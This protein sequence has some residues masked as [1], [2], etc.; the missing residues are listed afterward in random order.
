[1]R[2]VDISDFIGALPSPASG[3]GSARR[4]DAFSSDDASG[5]TSQATNIVEAIE[6]GATGL[7]LDEDT[8]ATNFMIR[9]ARMQALVAP[10]SEPI[11]PFLDRVRALH[12]ARG[13]STVLVMG[14]SGDYFDV[15][16][17]VV[18]MRDFSAH[19]ATEAA[20]AIARARPTG[21]SAEAAG[22][23]GPVR[24]RM[25]VAESFALGG[26]RGRRDRVSA[27]SRELIL[28][29]RTP[30]DLRHL[31]QIA[32]PSQTRAIALALRTAAA[33]IMGDDA[34]CAAGSAPSLAETLDS[35]ERMLDAEGLD[36]L[37]D[38]DRFGERGQHPGA[39]ARPRRF[40]IASAINRYRGLQVR[41]R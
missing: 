36:A 32:D 5:S 25:P 41:Q 23:L 27:K 33:R 13:V 16:D 40:E 15:A 38:V 11:T 17:R 8:S 9:D 18:L 31:S 2:G 28:F 4:T 12:D 29:G 34:A 1:V 30:I 26:G 20:R 21:R 10:E 6:V 3:A 37:A 39:L 22:P 14:G 7:L 24:A 19:D 35:L